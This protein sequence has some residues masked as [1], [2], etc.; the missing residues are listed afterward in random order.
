MLFKDYWRKISDECRVEIK[1]CELLSYYSDMSSVYWY[2]MPELRDAI[3]KLH[4]LVGNA[5]TN[6]M[7]IVV[8]NGFTQLFQAALY[9][10]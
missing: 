3:K 10:L 5:D 6:D 8:G 1:G 2:M 7:Y 4:A 9:A